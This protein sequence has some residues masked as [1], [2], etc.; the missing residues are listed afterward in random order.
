M[1]YVP[2]VAP[3]RPPS[4]TSCPPKTFPLFC[5]DGFLL[6]HGWIGGALRGERVPLLFVGGAG[7]CAWLLY[8]IMKAKT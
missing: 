7:A 5:D 8:K 4:D 3:R 2:Y 6:P 1:S